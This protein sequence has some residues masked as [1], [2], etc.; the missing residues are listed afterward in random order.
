MFNHGGVWP[1]AARHGWIGVDLFF[2]LSGFLISG[3]LFNEY[4]TCSSI[5]FKRFFIRRG[6][7]IYPAFYLFLFLT[8]LVYYL[9]FH[10]LSSRT[11]YLAEFFFVQNYWHGVWDHTWSLAVEEH[12]YIL[13]P[14]VLL[15]LVRR[16]PEQRNPFRPPGERGRR[17]A[18][19]RP[20]SE[21]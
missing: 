9:V 18:P 3:L 2:V 17:I 7:K 21:S 11:H 14:T 19:R 6:L 15:F 12:F 16:S 5:S 8:G 20:G 13:L 4:K 1:A 10:V